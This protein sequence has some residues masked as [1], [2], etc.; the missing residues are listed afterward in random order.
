MEAQP[1]GFGRASAPIMAQRVHTMR[2][3]NDGTG[4]KSDHGSALRIARRWHCQHVEPPHAVGAQV[5]EGHW[6]AGWG[7]GSCAHDGR[8]PRR[9]IC[10]KAAG[11]RRR[12]DREAD[13][14]SP[15]C[16][17]PCGGPAGEPISD[18]RGHARKR[19]LTAPKRSAGGPASSCSGG[20]RRDL[21]NGAAMAA[22]GESCRCCG[23]VL[24]ARFD[25][26]L[27]SGVQTFCVARSLIT[28]SPRPRWP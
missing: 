5:A 16:V 8:I 21:G 15:R 23:H 27:P 17:M 12:R 24:M 9:R 7:S 11:L 3:P 18:Q 10:R 22:F 25:P 14:L 13:A 28:G 6:G 2:G 1:L 26:L 20:I 4:T 19:M